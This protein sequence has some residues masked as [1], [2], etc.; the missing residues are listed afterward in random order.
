MRAIEVLG[1][2]AGKVSQETR[3]IGVDVPWSSI[4]SMRNRLIHGYFDIDTEIVWK[5]MTNEIPALLPALK[6]LLD[7]QLDTGNE[8]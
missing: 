1:E 5:T 4:V 7:E 6:A 2:A 3:S 8:K